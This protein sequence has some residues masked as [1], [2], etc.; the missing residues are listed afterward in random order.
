MKSTTN[1]LK[2]DLKRE[3]NEK[4]RKEEAKLIKVFNKMLS[5]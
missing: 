4:Q 2:I 1:K 3:R 5:I